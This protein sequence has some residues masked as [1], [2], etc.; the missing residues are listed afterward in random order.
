MKALSSNQAQLNGYKH[1][2]VLK[3]SVIDKPSEEHSGP[4]EVNHD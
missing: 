4:A 2:K 3:G 1:A